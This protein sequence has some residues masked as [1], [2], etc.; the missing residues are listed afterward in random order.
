ML[1]LDANHG[2]FSQLEGDRRVHLY[3]KHSGL[4]II[5]NFRIVL[6]LVA[7]IRFFDPYSD[8]PGLG[9]TPYEIWCDLVD[10]G[11]RYLHIGRKRLDINPP[12][13]KF[14]KPPLPI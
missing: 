12:L 11:V 1:V 13:F 14:Y 4:K 8:Y 5:P 9:N 3:W 10:S 7:Q 2:T 6:D